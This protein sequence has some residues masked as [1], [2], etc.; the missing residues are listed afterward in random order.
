M[1]DPD[2]L[3]L[4][5]PAIFGAGLA[6]G[7]LWHSRALRGEREQRIQAQEQARRV[8]ELE[9]IIDSRD[10][11]LL[12]I[13]EQQVRYEEQAKAAKEQLKLLEDA[14]QRLTETFKALSAD[15]LRQNNQVFMEQAKGTFEQ[16]HKPVRETLEKTREYLKGLELAREGAYKSLEQQ[17]KNL[18]EQGNFL[19][20][21]TRG[22]RS[23]LRTPTVA[24]RWG[25][26]QLRRV[27]ELAGLQE[28]C[29]FET[30]VTDDDSRLRPDLIVRLPGG[31]QVIVDAK[32]PL[33]DY[34]NA[35]DTNGE[36]ELRKKL[37]TSY[38]SKVRHHLKT[39]SAKAYWERFQPAPA[40]VI[41][42]L[43]GEAFYQA[44]MRESR[45]LL[46]T[47][48]AHRVLPAG[49]LA[50]IALL[51]TVA[52][53]WRDRKFA[54]NAEQVRLLGQELYER[55][56]TLLKHWGRLGENLNST[57]ECY[58]KAVGSMAARVLPAARKMNELGTVTSGKELPSP[59]LVDAFA[60]DLPSAPV[61]PSETPGSAAPESNLQA[62]S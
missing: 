15:S 16:Y 3:L 47:A 24:G 58:N 19:Q 56:G 30:Q 26:A 35:M 45:E 9:A 14:R 44:A 2:L 17:I 11:E 1:N 28:H 37:L 50:L 20:A 43:P 22:L 5:A 31:A 40:F 54:E 12:A 62:E 57:V 41:M 36:E 7:L 13:H 10:Q 6:V 59:A 4:L 60:R 55:I 33:S 21:E 39:L 8:S 42:Y 38:A 23:A 51:H 34:F 27:V 29:D 48:A 53:G 32:A 46:E 18:L 25:E 49:P 52:L 61:D